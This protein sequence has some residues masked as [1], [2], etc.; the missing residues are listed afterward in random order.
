MWQNSVSEDHLFITQRRYLF[1]QGTSTSSGK[2]NSHLLNKVRDQES[3]ASSDKGYIS[4]L[5]AFPV[6]SVQVL[7]PSHWKFTSKLRKSLVRAIGGPSLRISMASWMP[8][9]SVPAF[10]RGREENCDKTV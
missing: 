1:R 10:S 8:V 5:G 4:P 6:Q 9:C 7:D 2:R 3:V